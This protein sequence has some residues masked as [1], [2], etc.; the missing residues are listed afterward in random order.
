[1]LTLDP[2]DSA[3][4]TFAAPRARPVVIYTD[5]SGRYRVR[6]PIPPSEGH[7]LQIRHS[8]Y[9]EHYFDEA[10]PPYWKQDAQERRELRGATSVHAPLAG[11][12]GE[13]IRYDFVLFPTAKLTE[14]GEEGKPAP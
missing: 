5:E 2:V 10:D 1:M 13:K 7:K 3:E 11:K 8:D 12:A 4:L 6:L 9:A 14:K